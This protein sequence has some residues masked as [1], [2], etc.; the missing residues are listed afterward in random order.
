MMNLHKKVMNLYEKNGIR[1][2]STMTQITLHLLP[3]LDS[4]VTKS[5]VMRDKTSSSSL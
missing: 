1:M 5:I 4:P 3:A 2:L